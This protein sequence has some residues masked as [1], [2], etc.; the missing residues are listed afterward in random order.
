MQ[1]HLVIILL[2]LIIKII[3]IQKIILLFII[4]NFQNQK[5]KDFNFNSNIK[6]LL[7]DFKNDISINKI[8]PEKQKLKIKKENNTSL[9][10][11][12]NYNNFKTNPNE[13]FQKI[14]Q[15]SISK[16]KIKRRKK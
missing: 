10:I 6:K 4:I 3:I 8:K 13:N 7:N 16:I 9:N 11:N 5:L 15:L 2:Q 1:I 14:N 12:I